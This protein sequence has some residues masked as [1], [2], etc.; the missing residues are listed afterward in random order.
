MARK[1]FVLTAALVERTRQ[2]MVH[3]REVASRGTHFVAYEKLM[4]WY[5]GRVYAQKQIIGHGPNVKCLGDF[6]PNLKESLLRVRRF[7]MAE[8]R[9]K[10]RRS[11]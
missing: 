1:K 4:M 3:L 8:A 11:R 6:S 9:K 5:G 2:K 7:A 10:A